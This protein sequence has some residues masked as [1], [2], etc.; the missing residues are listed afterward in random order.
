MCTFF[1]SIYKKIY[2]TAYAECNLFSFVTPSTVIS[3]EEGRYLCYIP[4]RSKFLKVNKQIP[5]CIPRIMLIYL[6]RF[7]WWR[8]QMEAFPRYWPFVWG[9]RKGQWRGALIF[10]LICAWINGWVNDF[11]AGDLRRHRAHCNVIVMCRS[12]IEW[13]EGD[14]FRIRLSTPCF[15]AIVSSIITIRWP[16]DLHYGHSYTGNVAAL[17][18]NSL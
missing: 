1:I 2:W 3:C 4:L 7:S 5:K 18:W 14:E 12:D 11:K 16:W 10:S 15:N 8:H 6:L 13:S 9:I 17:Y